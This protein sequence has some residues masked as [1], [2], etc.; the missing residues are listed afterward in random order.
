M[1]VQLPLSLDPFVVSGRELYQ[2]YIKLQVQT[3]QPI[4]AVTFSCFKDMSGG[5]NTEYWGNSVFHYLR[6]VIHSI[7]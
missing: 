2:A 5:V 4:L 6:K 3:K 7:F 1:V